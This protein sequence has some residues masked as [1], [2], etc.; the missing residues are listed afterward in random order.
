MYLKFNRFDSILLLFILIS[1]GTFSIASSSKQE[2]PKRGM[3]KE[4]DGYYIEIKNTNRNFNAYL[5]NSEKEP[6]STKN[7][8]A[9]AQFFFPDSTDLEI[10]LKPFNKVAFTCIPPPGYYGCKI[11]FNIM[12]KSVSAKF[13]SQTPIV[14]MD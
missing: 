3:I 14:L 13:P 2:D 11:T 7:I 1:L 6:M 5:L 8:Y 12:G 4:A 9:K 10:D